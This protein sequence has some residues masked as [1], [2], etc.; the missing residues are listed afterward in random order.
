MQVLYKI[1]IIISK[2]V[3]NYNEVVVQVAV[4]YFIACLCNSGF[5]KIALARGG[6]D[7]F[8]VHD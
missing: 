6:S 8:L 2:G 1:S 5:L 4:Y 3:I 7:D